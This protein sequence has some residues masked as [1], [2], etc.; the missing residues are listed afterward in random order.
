MEHKEIF[1]ELA[2]CKIKGMM[3]HSNMADFYAFLNCC[4][5][6][7]LHNKRFIEESEELRELKDYYIMSYGR[8]LLTDDS[9]LEVENITPAEWDE[10]NFTPAERIKYIKYGVEV[11]EAYEQK[12]HDHMKKLADM[13]YA[14]GCYEDYKMVRKLIDDVILELSR[15]RDLRTYIEQT[16]F[17]IDTDEGIE[18][19]M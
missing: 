5:F 8:T 16:G 11:Y 6:K 1:K 15:V 4:K 10:A 18:Y 9:H 2:N 12:T 14:K 19:R 7:T 17:N 13:L 3:F